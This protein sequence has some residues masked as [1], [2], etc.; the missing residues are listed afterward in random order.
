MSGNHL[1]TALKKQY[2]LLNHISQRKLV[3]WKAGGSYNSKA[4]GYLHLSRPELFLPEWKRKDL[5]LHLGTAPVPF[6]E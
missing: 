4:L 1:P 6:N 3:K 5:D 2:T